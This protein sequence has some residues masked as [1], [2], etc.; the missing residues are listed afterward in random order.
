MFVRTIARPIRR[1]LR[2]PFLWTRRELRV[3]IARLA[4]LSFHKG[5]VSNQNT[6]FPVSE[7]RQRCCSIEQPK[8]TTDVQIQKH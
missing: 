2:G 7:S 3:A 6:G 8:L 4:A 5:M 1:M